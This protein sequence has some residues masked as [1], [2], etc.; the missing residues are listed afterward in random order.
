MRRCLIVL[1]LSFVSACAYSPQQI[2]IAP[3]IGAVGERFGEG[4]AVN[5]VAEDQREQQ[6]I[7]SMG[8]LYADSSTITISN[9][10][11]DAIVQAASAKLAAQGYNVNSAQSGTEMKIIVDEIR[12][13]MEKV[14][15]RKK[16][17][18]T[19]RLN[20][21]LTNGLRSYN[22]KY[23]TNMSEEMLGA[24]DAAQNESMINTQLA[25]T[26]ERA[27]MDPRVVDFIRAE[28]STGIT[29]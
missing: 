16:V 25:K 6:V 9:S 7:G 19:T 13:E 20:V 23:Q 22:G 4:R 10:L 15:L 12:Y 28:E 27:F 18:L 26:L 24:P 3:V 1:L 29:F 8:G 5:V 11:T 2:K 21:E 14:G 17:S